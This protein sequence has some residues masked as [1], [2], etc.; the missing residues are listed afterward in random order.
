M[1]WKSSWGEKVGI[2][3]RISA[4]AFREDTVHGGGGRFGRRDLRTPVPDGVFLWYLLRVGV[5]VE[6]R[7]TSGEAIKEKERVFEGKI[8]N[9]EKTTPSNQGAI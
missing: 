4:R 5:R 7:K 9:S 6:S 1:E 2:S 3:Q 8:E